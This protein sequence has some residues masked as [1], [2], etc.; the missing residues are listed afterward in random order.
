MDS[1]PSTPAHKLFAELWLFIAEDL[2]EE[3]NGSRDVQSMTLVNRYLKDVMQPLLFHS[4][5]LHVLLDFADDGT[6]VRHFH[7]TR[8]IPL[9]MERL[10]F[11]TSARIAPRIQ[12]VEVGSYSWKWDSRIERHDGV[13][14]Q[15]LIH[16]LLDK[17]PSFVNLARVLLQQIP[18]DTHC[19]ER[20]S[21]VQTL[22]ELSIIACWLRIKTFPTDDPAFRLRKL[23]LR[24]DSSDVEDYDNPWLAKLISCETEEIDVTKDNVT[25]TLLSALSTMSTHLRSLRILLFHDVATRHPD[26]HRLLAN[27]PALKE[28]RLTQS[29]SEPDVVQPI[30]AGYVPLLHTITGPWHIVKVYAQ[31]PS[32]RQLPHIVTDHHNFLPRVESI[33]AIRP[34]LTHLGISVF[35]SLHDINAIRFALVHFRSLKSFT[36][37]AYTVLKMVLDDVC[38]HVTQFDTD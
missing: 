13:D 28:L 4:V 16:A 21:R 1:T 10:D 34:E 26:F 17:L 32:V 37:T 22:T 6:L 20:L 2:L 29:G 7:A 12:Y 11:V 38:L 14:A 33:H 35:N 9:F 5:K 19:L 23:Y 24:V 8:F 31:H 15:V 25:R 3:E 36:I 18:L 30:P 27:C